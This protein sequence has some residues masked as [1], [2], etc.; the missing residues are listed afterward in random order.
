MRMQPSTSCPNFV[1]ILCIN[2]EKA[3]GYF[4]VRVDGCKINLFRDK[5][6]EEIKGYKISLRGKHER[7][8][9]EEKEENFNRLRSLY[10]EQQ[11]NELQ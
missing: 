8:L 7:L 1:S 2:N 11:K 5:T 3:E 4:A 6:T 9:K 10:S